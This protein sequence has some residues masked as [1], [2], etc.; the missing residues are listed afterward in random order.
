MTPASDEDAADIWGISPARWRKLKRWNEIPGMVLLR[1]GGNRRTRIF[2]REQLV[3]ARAAEQ[4]AA[5]RDAVVEYTL[6]AVPTT[7]HPRDLLDLEEAR[8][9]LPEDRR[10]S[11]ATWKGYRY[12]DKTRL[13]EPDTTVGNADLWYRQTI[14]DW[15]GQRPAPGG[16][17][18]RA[19]R[20]RGSKDSVPRGEKASTEER[21]Q[22]VM[23]LLDEK[24]TATADDVHELIPGFHLVTA[25]R[26]L[27]DAREHIV[28]RAVADDPDLTVE[29]VRKLFGMDSANAAQLLRESGGDVPEHYL[30]DPEAAAAERRTVG[31][32]L[33][34]NNHLTIEEVVDAVGLTPRRAERLLREAR[35][36]LLREDLADEPDRSVEEVQ[37]R[38]SMGRRPAAVRLLADAGGRLAAG[39]IE[40]VARKLLTRNPRLTTQELAGVTGAD[41]GRA[42][43]RLR[44]ARVAMLHVMLRANPTFSV[45]D[46][47]ELFGLSTRDQAAELISDASD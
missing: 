7:E 44:R 10:P 21:R 33:R 11:P 19:G 45:D 31:G 43:A 26:A 6:P 40:L 5:G 46:T 8:L 1:E 3:A 28:R 18:G 38:F 14:S 39:E 32:L 13:P 17:K 2:S 27:R 20:P 12:G 23:R 42:A 30:V 4:H 9:S 41:A 34:V 25:Q 35:L 36:E 16:M 15:D 37:R 22:R 24:P 47:V 29:G